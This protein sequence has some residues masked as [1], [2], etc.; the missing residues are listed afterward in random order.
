MLIEQASISVLSIAL[1][2]VRLKPTAVGFMSHFKYTLYYEVY[3]TKL[4][5]Y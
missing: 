4:Y 5:Y 2:E 3:V 1:E